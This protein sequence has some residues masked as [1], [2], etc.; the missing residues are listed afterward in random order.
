MQS[1]KGKVAVVTGGNGVLGSAIATGLA[2][3][4]VRVGILGRTEE[5]VN[6]TV[7]KIISNNGAA[8]P[9]I[10]DVLD[11]TSLDTAHQKVIHSWGTVDILINAAGGN[12]PGATVMPEQTIFDL[13]I[14]SF[15]SVVDLNL[16][17]TLLPILVFGKS[18]HNQKS[19]VIIN[20]SSM[21]AQRALTRVA[22]YSASKAGIDALTRWL[23]VEMSMKHGERIRVNA[24]APGFFIGEQNKKLL[25]KEDGTLTERGQQIV[26]Q[27]PMGR[28]GNPEELVGAVNWLC[29][30]GASFVTGAIIP[31]D[32]GFGSFSGV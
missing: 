28:F 23:S 12:Q 2:N 13:D 3:E 11:R 30:D 32:G 24:I 22:G 31:I 8:I 15:D 7:N 18:F 17:G 4:G 20:V 1:L 29:S 27:T 5:S 25:L 16:K 6:K 26:S 9:L 14:D 21:A 19:G 10:A